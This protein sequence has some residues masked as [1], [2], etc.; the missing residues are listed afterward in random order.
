MALAL[1]LV[2]TAAALAHRPRFPEGSGPFEVVD[3]VVSQAFYLQ[4]APGERHL[5]VLPPLPEAVPL[6]L[7]VLDDEAGRAL[8]LRARLRCGD[9]G[10]LLDATDQ[11]FFE[12]FSRME[13]RYRAVDSAGPT[14]RSCEVLVWER[15]GQGGSY[16]FAV[17]SEESF[18]FGDVVGLLNLGRRLD[19]W[20]SGP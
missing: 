16:V 17:G 10:R 6:Q 9:D 2:L 1:L 20:R 14:E 13:M 7:L 19:A 5:F 8:D 11:P 4:L 15:H 12:A 3:P 18:T